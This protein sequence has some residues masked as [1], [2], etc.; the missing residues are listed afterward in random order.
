M[1]DITPLANGQDDV[2][3]SRML[4]EQ[5]RVTTIPASAFYADNP[6]RNLIRFAFCKRPEVLIEAL[7]RMEMWK[8][9]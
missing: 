6:P 9:R 4:T 2:A 3:F 5:A 1:A 8:N 7:N